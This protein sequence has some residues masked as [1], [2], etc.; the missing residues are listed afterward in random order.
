[1]GGQKPR[2]DRFTP[3]KGLCTHCTEAGWVPGPT[4]TGAGN[5]TPTGIR[6]RDRP[7][8]CGLG[9]LGRIITD[10]LRVVRFSARQGYFFSSRRPYWLWGVLGDLHRQLGN[11]GC[12]CPEHT[13]LV[14]ELYL[15]CP[16]APSWRYDQARVAGCSN[17]S[18]ATA[19][20][21]G[22]T[23]IKQSRARQNFSATS[24]S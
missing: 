3:G 6:L 4:W 2:P 18:Y 9:Y 7:A 22:K 19:S 14:V 11:R 10:P 23:C 17:F 21:E 1:M 24:L 13:G 5:F 20:H 15:V 8:R 12:K 16:Y